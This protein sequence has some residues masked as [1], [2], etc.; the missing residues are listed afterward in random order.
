V[1]AGAADK[2]ALGI[3]V[4]GTHVRAAV[5]D[6]AGKILRHTRH[7]LTKRDPDSLLQVV[8]EMRAELGFTPQ[9]PI[10][11]GMGLAAVL[12]IET[13]LVAVAP[14][15]SW[16]DVPFGDMLEKRFGQ[17]VRMVND[18]N[19]IAVGE[20]FSGAGEGASDV[21]CVFVG[22]GV[23]MGAVVRGHVIE[24]ADG[25]ATE[26]GHTKIESVTAGRACG[27]G[28]RGCL[29]A[30]TS[31]RHLPDLLLAKVAEGL[32]SPLV[33]AAGGK[34]EKMTAGH[35][36]AAAQANDPA[37]MAL[38]EDIT[39]RLA[40]SI[41]N[42]MTLFNPRVLVLGGGVLVSAPSLKAAVSQRIKNYAGRPQQKNL[43]IR[44][45][46]LADDAGV[47]GAALLALESQQ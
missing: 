13:G 45:T 2:R 37:A 28:E 14:N 20:G 8:A 30:Y 12:W 40:R 35:I 1:S 18:L 41:G 19:A 36:E 21:V 5:V 42:T 9:D 15:L 38:W 33:D 10:P 34:P 17:R 44:D 4:G 16:F 25:L 43:I 39:E 31:G 24:G 7:N 26:L 3:D 11:M 27:C 47:I 6:A 46:K 29:E 22:T 32:K 23:G